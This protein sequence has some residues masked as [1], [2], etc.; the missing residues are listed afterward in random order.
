MAVTGVEPVTLPVAKPLLEPIVATATPPARP[1]ADQVAAAVLSMVDPSL[2]VSISVNCWVP[3]TGI[4]ATAGVT[5]S[6]TAVAA[7]TVK[8]AV[9]MLPRYVAVMLDVP[10]TLPVANPLVGKSVETVA[11]AAPPTGTLVAAQAAA[12]VLSMV[13][14][15]LNVSITVYCW[16]PE[17]GIEVAS[18]VTLSVNEVAAFTFKVAV[19]GDN[20]LAA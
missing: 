1:G 20:G 15:S 4:E 7:F 12:A 13:E 2:N 17:T 16:V 9:A 19:A 6:D 18:G 10:T 8:V 3:V 5:L 14:P 11:T